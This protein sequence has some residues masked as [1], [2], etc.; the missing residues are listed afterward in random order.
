[1]LSAS[2]LEIFVANQI[3]KVVKTSTQEWIQSEITATDQDKNHAITFVI[4]SMKC[5]Q[6]TILIAVDSVIF[7]SIICYKI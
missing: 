4:K 7:S 2:F 6:V 5:I 3:A 1:V